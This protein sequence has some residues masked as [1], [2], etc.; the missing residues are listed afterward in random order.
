MSEPER[1]LF[2]RGHGEEVKATG[3]LELQHPEP[4]ASSLPPRLRGGA[5][6][7]GGDPG[8]GGGAGATKDA[9]AARGFPCLTN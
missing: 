2:L 9:S 7:G 4:S 6:E 8:Q 5:T 3:G 1:G